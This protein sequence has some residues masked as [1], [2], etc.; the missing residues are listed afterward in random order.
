MQLPGAEG[1]A[2]EDDDKDF[3]QDG[4]EGDVR[5]EEVAAEKGSGEG[6]EGRESQGREDGGAGWGGA[7]VEAAEWF[8][9]GGFCLRGS[10]GL[11]G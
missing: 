1:D 5:N 7:G 4:D 3:G 8:E 2:S 6:R 9:D 11:A 10:A